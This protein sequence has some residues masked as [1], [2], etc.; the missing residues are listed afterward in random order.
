MASERWRAIVS[1]GLGGVKI[2]GKRV[3]F[4]NFEST[5]KKKEKIS[6]TNIYKYLW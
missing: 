4:W 1:E 6:E 3:K 2:M 5:V